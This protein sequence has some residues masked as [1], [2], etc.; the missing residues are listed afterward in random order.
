M[1]CATAG[2]VAA[3]GARVSPPESDDPLDDPEAGDG[4][5]AAREGVIEPGA[6]G[7]RAEE[8]VGSPQHRAAR[9]RERDLSELDAQG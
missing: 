6:P 4:A 3:S 8:L 9:G 2:T 7:R 1:Q 5:Q